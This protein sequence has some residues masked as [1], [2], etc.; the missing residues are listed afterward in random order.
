VNTSSSG[1]PT[2]RFGAFELDPRAGELRKKGMK[3]KLQGQ[4]VEILVMLLER[5]GATITREELQKKLWPADTFVDFEQGLNNAMNR[6][7]AALDDDAESPRFIQTL[8]R[9]GYRFI[10]TVNGAGHGLAADSPSP[11][12]ARWLRFRWP[13]V[14]A[15][16]LIILVL[17]LSVLRSQ[18][19]PPPKI[20]GITQ[21]TSDGREKSGYV[22]TDGLRIYFSEQVDDHW[23]VAAVSSSGGQV[24]PIRTPVT[25]AL[26]LNISPD[27]SE[28]LVG[29][30]GDLVEMPLWLVP[31][32]GGPPRRLGSMLAHSG[33]WSPNGRKFVY[34]N[35]SALY[36][37][38]PDGTGPQE[39]VRG[40]SDP[41]IL[42]V[43]PT[44]SPDGS[45]V[46]FTLHHTVK[47]VGALWEITADGK[48]LHQVLPGWQSLPMHGGGFWTADGRYY[49]FSSWKGLSTVSYT[50]F[51][52]APA[53]EIWAIRE[54]TNML[55]NR[56]SV[57]IQLTVGPL[58]FSGPIPSLDGKALF[59]TSLQSRGELMRYDVRTRHLSPYLSG[60]SAQGVNFSKDGAW[61]T[62]VTFPQGELWRCRTD[63]SERLQ[64]T[65]PPM[66]VHDPHWAPDGKRIAYS[67]L[68]AG[69]Q[70]QLYLVSADGGSS[71]RLLPESEAGIDPTWSR[72]GNSLL[73]GQPPHVAADMNNVPQILKILNLQTRRV[74]VVPGSEGLHGPR[75][76][77]DGRYISATSGSGLVLFDVAT[78]KWIEQVRGMSAGW[79]AWSRD[80][81]YVYFLGG[82]LFGAGPGIFRVAVNNS[83]KLEKVLSLK[84]F[85]PA[86]SFG[87][88][89]SLTPDD[90]PLVLRDVGPPE[91]YALS[92]EAP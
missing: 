71:Q 78:Q 34:A 4:P 60:I 73:F 47:N 82:Y 50:T 52:T 14:A 75:W 74:S 21:L 72:D 15:F 62:Y 5:S 10:G 16:A 81:R 9:H 35:G 1:P 31:I 49:L 7:R 6:L 17:V 88:W 43:L 20:I 69:G 27:R 76:S 56:S 83:N 39:L 30:G 8:P 55:G 33:A 70:W 51:G 67:G 66:V 22:A 85:R 42:A 28:L 29:E 26:L 86:G 36:L 38:K 40:D 77:P 90:D 63:Q 65:F 24:V 18:P 46:R 89:L 3:I 92:W 32:L 45:R 87:A 57:P 48:N 68:Q 12:S 37:T 79:Q 23:T 84:D 64:L 13:A 54:K 19:P 11:L 61:M 53:F 25:D 58:H 2:F 59:A 91:I 44:W 80:A 41:S